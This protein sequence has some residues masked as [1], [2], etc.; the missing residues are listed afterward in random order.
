[1][2]VFVVLRWWVW[3]AV[4]FAGLAAGFVGDGML[5]RRRPGWRPVRRQ[6]V[7]ATLAPALILTG[8]AA[9][10]VFIGLTAPIGGWGDL[11]VAAIM[12]MGATVAFVAF[13]AGLCGAWLG[14][15]VAAA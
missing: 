11:A 1:M 15:R 4:A 13:V 14:S 5:E 6:L 10:M 9:G 12:M 8:T 7:A 2:A 3:L